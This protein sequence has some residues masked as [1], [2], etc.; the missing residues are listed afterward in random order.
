M[1]SIRKNELPLPC[2]E[3][4]SRREAARVAEHWNENPWIPVPGDYHL[5][6]DAAAFFKAADVPN[7]PY[8]PALDFY[9]M[10]SRGSLTILPCF[11]TYQQTRPYTCASAAALMVMDYF[12]ASGWQELQI[13]DAMAAYHGLP[14]D[15]RRPVPVSDLVR[16]F[17]EL[18]WEVR[19]NLS[20]AC[21]I[22]DDPNL[23]PWRLTECLTFPTLE[24]FTRF[25]R[26]TLAEGTPIIVENIDWGGHW[27]IIIGYDD[28]GTDSAAHGVL[29][30][31]DPHD[32]ADHCQD[33]YVTEHV[34]KFYSTWYDMFIMSR[35]ERAQP[36][37]TARPK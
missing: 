23:P 31:A 33:G 14:K 21:R 32:T 12:G 15:T 6:S 10:Y 9:H 7:S 2:L 28:M 18:G 29:I 34:D 35:E 19:S 8:F 24:E 30:L 16:F 3:A 25:V 17:T 4:L 22:P 20:V 36:W 13:A 27:R 11:K 1:A 37:L 5:E 26:A